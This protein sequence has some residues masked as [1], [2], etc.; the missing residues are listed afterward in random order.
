MPSQR[1]HAV[2]G[3][4]YQPLTTMRTILLVVG[5][6]A[7]VILGIIKLFEVATIGGIIVLI[8]L[9]IVIAENMK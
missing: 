6:L 9:A 2:E 7:V 4:R 1:G 8:I 3:Q 5:L